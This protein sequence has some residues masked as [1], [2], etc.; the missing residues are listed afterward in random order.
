MLPSI[1]SGARTLAVCVP[2]AFSGAL[3][4]HE[5]GA[6]GFQPHR[7][8][9]DLTLQSAETQSGI[10]A[11]A[12]KMVFEVQGS[13]C[14]GYSVEFRLITEITATNGAVRLTD[15]RTSSFEAGNGQDFQFLSKTFLDQ[16]LSQESRGKATRSEEILEVELTEPSKR[17][18]TF[19]KDVLFPSQHF[20]EIIRLAEAGENFYNVG[21]YDGSEGGDTFFETA[22]VIGK[23]RDLTVGNEALAPRNLRHWPVVISYYDTRTTRADSMPIYTLSFMTNAPG[24]SRDIKM[25]YNSFVIKGDLADLEFF[26]SE[27]CP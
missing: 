6:A 27:D 20:F 1:P 5:A 12:G 3:A 21:V 22:T 26:N 10:S 11:L 2:F 9:Y 24:I 16:K 14:E 25:D 13:V 17:T 19:G 15:V 4:V 23:P 7:A 8:V 18:V